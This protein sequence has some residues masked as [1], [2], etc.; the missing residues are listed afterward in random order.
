M[1][2]LD[3]SSNTK[4]VFLFVQVELVLDVEAV[5]PEWLRRWWIWEYETVTA[6]DKGREFENMLLSGQSLDAAEVIQRASASYCCSVIVQY[7]PCRSDHLGYDLYLSQ[8][9]VDFL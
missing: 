9:P 7:M 1:T 2:V 5:L 3:S 6:K 4:I 8:Y